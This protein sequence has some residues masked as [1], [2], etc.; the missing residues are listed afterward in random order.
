MNYQPTYLGEISLDEETLTHYGVKGM[1]WRHRKVRKH[2]VDTDRARRNYRHN[3]ILAKNAIYMIN[4]KVVSKEEWD[5]QQK[6]NAY[7][8]RNIDQTRRFNKQADNARTIDEHNALK[9]AAANSN[10]GLWDYNKTHDG[11]R[12]TR[13]KKSK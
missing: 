10:S 11:Y 9:I 7:A 3:Q 13:R 1:K 5:E 12:M 4:G 6:A 2:K 8:S